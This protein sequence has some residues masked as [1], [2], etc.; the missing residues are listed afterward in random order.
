MKQSTLLCSQITG[1]SFIPI[2]DITA[3]SGWLLSNPKNKNK[4]FDIGF[5][6]P[7][8]TSGGDE[9]ETDGEESDVE[10]WDTLSNSFKKAQAVLNQNRELIQRVNENHQSK[11]PDNLVKNVGLIREINGNISKVIEIYL[12]LSVNFLDTVD[13]RK[14]TGNG[15]LRDFLVPSNLAG[16][17]TYT[18]LKMEHS[19]DR[20]QHA[21]SPPPPPRLEVH[22]DE[23]SNGG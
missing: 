23:E 18:S 17:Q 20:S 6:K 8:G 1:P 7:N 14:R 12:N 16:R 19:S 5:E 10:V 4:R 22:E 2:T 11:I 9:D 3:I 21:P 15:K 13:Q